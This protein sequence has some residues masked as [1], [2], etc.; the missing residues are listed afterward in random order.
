MEARKG[1]K[2]QRGLGF[3]FQGD[4]TIQGPMFDIHD[5]QN[6]YLY[7][8]GPSDDDDEDDEEDAAVEDCPEF[9]R[10]L[11]VEVLTR[12]TIAV[13]PYMWGQSS[14]AVLFCILRDIYSYKGNMSQFERGIT[15]IVENHKLEWACPDGTIRVAFKHNPYMKL[16]VSKWKSN[17]APD[18]VIQLINKFEENVG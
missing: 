2:K 14:N 1:K 13:Q 5:N 6:V 9:S 8:Q 4:V 15:A 7:G 12:A 18:R 11:N 10:A 3:T 16:H 17:G